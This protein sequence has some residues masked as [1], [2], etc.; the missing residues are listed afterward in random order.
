V[1]DPIAERAD[2]CV[3]GD[4]QQGL[5][6]LPVEPASSLIARSVNRLVED[7]AYGPI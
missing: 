4:Q 2:L 6:A 3:V 7:P 1:D 5:T